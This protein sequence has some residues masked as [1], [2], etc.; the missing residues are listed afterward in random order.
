MTSPDPSKRDDE[1]ITNNVRLDTTSRRSVLRKSALL[2]AAGVSGF[3]ATSLVGTAAAAGACGD[4]DPDDP[5]TTDYVWEEGDDKVD[6]YNCGDNVLRGQ[7]TVHA[8]SVQYLG[9]AE[10]RAGEW[11]H[12]FQLGGHV[13]YYN[14]GFDCSTWDHDAGVSEHKATID[15]KDGTNDALDPANDHDV[16]GLPAAGSDNGVLSD[17]GQELAMTAITEAMGYYWGG[18]AGAA[19]GIAIGIL[20]DSENNN[21]VKDSKLAYDWDYG[22]SYSKC[23]SHF[24]DF[25]VE[26]N[27]SVSLDVTDEAWGKYPNYT[28]VYKEIDFLDATPVSEQTGTRSISSSDLVSRNDGSRRDVAPGDVI[29]TTNGEP[30]RVTDVDVKTVES[31]GRTPQTIS[32]ASDLPRRLSHRFDD[33]EPVQYAEFPAQVRTISVS[34]KRIE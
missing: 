2:S 21:T 27:E 8:A 7:K 4:D 1:S 23:G 19:A 18:W 31:H 20:A 32:G 3:G 14:G 25:D 29:E 33:E 26:G 13:E 17:V 12:F 10:D 15:N 30:V 16:A 24:V 22:T 9:S 11:S 5:G 34:G 28:Q 6:I